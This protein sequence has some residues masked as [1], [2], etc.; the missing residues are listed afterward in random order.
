MRDLL[1][2]NFSRLFRSWVLLGAALVMVGGAVAICIGAYHNMVLYNEP[3]YT[4][5]LDQVLFQA[6]QA[7]GGAAAIVLSVFVGAEYSSGTIRNQLM[8]GKSRETVYF[9]EYLT[10][11]VGAFIL[12][13]L[14]SLTALALGSVLFSA[15]SVAPGT[16]L[17]AFFVGAMTCLLYTLFGVSTDEYIAQPSQINGTL[18]AENEQDFP[19]CDY[20]YILFYDEKTDKFY[21]VRFEANDGPVIPDFIEARELSG[22][23]YQLEL[24]IVDEVENILLKKDSD[25]A[26][27]IS[28][29]DD[30][31]NILSALKNT[32]PTT[33]S[34][35]L[36]T[37]VR[38]ETI[39]NIDFNSKEDVIARLFLYVDK[40]EYF[41]E[42]TGNGVYTISK[43]DYD[44]IEKYLPMV[45]DEQT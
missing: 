4:E 28:S 44:S 38:V 18:N 17:I 13:M 24:P 1:R 45:I 42:Q 30:V 2:A 40:G 5:P 33:V 26:I 27:T 23:V 10:C 34:E 15:S 41:I 19:I 12:F 32:K 31:E 14:P 37:P 39:I 6:E 20:E 11:V 22:A 9:A 8:V 35:E 29:R 36:G 21:C 3:G 43:E 25:P 16:I 7:L